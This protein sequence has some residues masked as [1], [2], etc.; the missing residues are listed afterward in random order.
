MLLRK[1]C[2]IKKQK[3]LG[4]WHLNVHWR[5]FEIIVGYMSTDSLFPLKNE[6][7]KDTINYIQAT[8]QLFPSELMN[9]LEIP[10][11]CKI[12]LFMHSLEA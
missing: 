5:R 10:F 2:N 3:S 4:H 6:I 7:G 1:I 9:N 11:R 12:G 8:R